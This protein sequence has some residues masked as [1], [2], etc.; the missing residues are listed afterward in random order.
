MFSEKFAA[1]FALPFSIVAVSF[2]AIF[3]RFSNANPISIAF[4]RMFFS[5]LIFL[6]L[7]YYYFEEFLMIS[8]R[9]WIILAGVGFLLGSHMAAWISS[10]EYTSVASSVVLVTSHP[11]LVSWLSSRYLDEETTKKGYFGII[12]ALAGITIMAFSDYRVSGWSLFGDFLA[13]TGMVLVS[14]YIIKGRQ[15]RKKLSVVPYVFI[16]YGFSSI[17]LAIF[18]IGVPQTFQI[19]PAREYILFL[20]LA[21]IPTMMGH[22]VYNWTLKF[23]K[24]R[25]ASISLLGEPIGSSILAFII[26]SEVPPRLTIIGAIVALFGIYLCQ[27]YG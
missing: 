22:T 25:I 6:P 26:L 17:F 10:L 23:V 11:L 13:I 27:R 9:Q 12:I 18:S 7:V 24:A 3:I 14:G 16:V 20:A 19:Y 4:H 8:R 21:I 1:R 15:M 5:T 2:A